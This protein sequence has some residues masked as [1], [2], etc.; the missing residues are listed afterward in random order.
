MEI[1]VQDLLEE[2][3]LFLKQANK[4]E[5]D[6][7]RTYIDKCLSFHTVLLVFIVCCPFAFILGSI[8]MKSP[9]P[10]DSRYPF[11]METTWVWALTYISMTV[12]TLQAAS[13]ILFDFLFATLLWFSGAR[14]EMSAKK[15]SRAANHEDVRR[16]IEDHQYVLK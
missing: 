7:T 3:H 11:S 16:C 2:L 5:S 8:A 4:E 13:T 10:I 9:L 12:M 15:L 1:F 14:M 6:V